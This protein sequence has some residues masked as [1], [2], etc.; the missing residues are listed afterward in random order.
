MSG[1]PSTCKSFAKCRRADNMI[2]GMGHPAAEERFRCERPAGW[3]G[4]TWS[5]GACSR[6]CG[7]DSDAQVMDWEKWWQLQK[8]RRAAAVHAL[9]NY[10]QN[11]GA[12]TFPKKWMLESGVTG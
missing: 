2:F 1:H 6:F 7:V 8:R 4:G 9:A 10:L 12:P 11:V 5:A 3:F